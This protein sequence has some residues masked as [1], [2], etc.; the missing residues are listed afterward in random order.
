MILIINK[1]KKDARSLAEIFHIMG[2]LAYAATPGEALSEISLQYSA[3]IVMNPSLL[4][5]KEE[6]AARLRSYAHIPIFAYCDTEKPEDKITFD[7]VIKSS[8]YATSILS[9]ISEYNYENGVKA[10]G[11]YRLA[12]IDAS[13]TLKTPLYFG[14]P[15]PLTK[16]E[17]MILKTLIVTYPRPT[18]AKEVLKY[19][20]KQNKT[21]E[22]SNIRTHISVINKKFRAVAERN[23]IALTVGEGYVILTPE[24][25]PS[26]NAALTN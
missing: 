23:L 2:V 24:L 10:P 14:K 22:A 3:V 7:G 5:A 16:T 26:F 20:F 21:P 18:S 9:V 15:L 25:M 13:M 11:I 12:G 8:S 1:S 4:P 6:Y 17:A 19:A